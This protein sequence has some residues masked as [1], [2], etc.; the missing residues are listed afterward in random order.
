MGGVA[1]NIMDSVKD[2]QIDE[3][4]LARLST[5]QA[6][7]PGFLEPVDIANT[8]LFLASDESRHLNGALIP[9]DMG[10]SAA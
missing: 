6:S 9:V 7:S 8:A 4:A 5:Y 2:R 10:W 1:T 3:A